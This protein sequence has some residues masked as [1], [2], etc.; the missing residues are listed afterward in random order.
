MESLGF[1]DDD[2]ATAKLLGLGKDAELAVYIWYVYAR[3][4][5][6]PGIMYWR[7]AL[8]TGLEVY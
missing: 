5:N 1:I 7:H 3:A 8:R 2:E 6:N 4:I